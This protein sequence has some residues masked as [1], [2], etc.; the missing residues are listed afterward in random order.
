MPSALVEE[1][2]LAA[3][4]FPNPASFEATLVLSHPAR[5]TME[6]VFY[7]VLGKISLRVAVP[8]NQKY[9]HLDLSALS[10]GVYFYRLV[11]QNAFNG[12][13]VT[14]LVGKLV[15]STQP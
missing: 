9:V 12:G 15:K 7:D 6:L 11:N 3:Q 10:D 5:E 2:N 1:E 14:Q 4:L 8:R 13:H